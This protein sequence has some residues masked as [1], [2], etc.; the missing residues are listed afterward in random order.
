MI[1]VTLKK[2]MKGGKAVWQARWPG[3][4]RV[5]G[6]RTGPGALSERQARGAVARL[7]VEINSEPGATVSPAVETVVGPAQSAVVFSPA[8]VWAKALQVLDQH[9]GGTVGAYGRA[10]AA[11]TAWVKAEGVV[12]D[13]REARRFAGDLA[14]T[15]KAN[16]VRAICR[17]CRSVYGHAEVVNPFSGIQTRALPKAEP[18]DLEPLEVEAVLR[19]L[20]GLPSGQVIGPCD[21]RVEWWIPWTEL[22]WGGGLRVNEAAYL[23]WDRVSAE[24][25]SIKVAPTSGSWFTAA[26]G[27]E[28]PM[29][30]WSGKTASR[31]NGPERV[32]VYRPVPLAARTAE[33]LRAWRSRRSRDSSPYVFVDLD[34]LEV[35]AK[36]IKAGR[37]GENANLIENLSRT[38]RRLQAEAGL[39]PPRASLHDLRAG[40]VAICQDAGMSIGECA[41]RLGDDPKTILAH[42]DRRRSGEADSTRAKLQAGA[43]GGTNRA[44]AEK[45]A[46]TAA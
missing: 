7:L 6:R 43:L 37:F 36:R 17:A 2:P 10:M 26:D 30:E 38:W 31:V 35:I 44:H 16:T 23:R 34:R 24:A 15:R 9:R 41:R 20:R 27:R 18:R 8:E 29:V 28:L 40:H 19:Y 11:L 39:D 32:L 12:L 45:T 13:S 42:Y 33:A 4:S 1:R 3:G 14:R 5:L 46:F 25:D 22:L 21:L